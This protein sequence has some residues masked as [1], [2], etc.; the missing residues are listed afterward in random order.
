MKRFDWEP[1]YTTISVYAFLVI[2]ASILF[3]MFAVNYEKVWGLIKTICAYLVPFAYGFGIAFILNPL[4]GFFERRLPKRRVSGRF[5]RNT[6]LLLAYLLSLVV[7]VIFFLVVIPTLAESVT[8]IAKNIAFY[9]AQVDAI[10]SELSSMIPE[11]LLSDEITKAI[12]QFVQSITSFV[13]TTLLQAVSL[14]TRVTS[15]VIDLIMGAII[16]L[17]MLANKETL[18]AQCKQILY[19]L[20]PERMVRWLISIAHDSNEKFSGFIIGKIIDSLIIGILCGIGMWIFKMP[21]ITLVSLIVGVTNIIPY[22]GPFIGAIPGILLVLIGGGPAQALGFALFV[23][24]LQQFDGNILGPAILGQST[25]LS[26]MWVIF[27]ILLF[28]GLYGFVGM[29]IGVPLLAVLFGLAKEFFNWRLEKKGLSTDVA[30]YAS[31]R[32]QLLTDKRKKNK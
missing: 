21:F 5:R 8:A 29:I 30:E 10:V 11:E 26:A 25:G 17:Y 16:S 9:S 14:T 32:H 12:D 22:F 3:G 27:A 24:V 13:V 6:A 31:S 19:A 1:R 7:A 2:A 15:G 4:V 18:F 20:F 28:G 23:L